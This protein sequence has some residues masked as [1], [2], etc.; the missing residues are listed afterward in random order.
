MYFL[1]SIVLAMAPLYIHKRLNYLT[2]QLIPPCL[3]PSMPHFLPPLPS[4]FPF[5][6]GLVCSTVAFDLLEILHQSFHRES[7]EEL[8]LGSVDTSCCRSGHR[9]FHTMVF[10]AAQDVLPCMHAWIPEKQANFNPRSTG[11]VR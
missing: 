9:Q 8:A 5:L 1:S 2:E 3:P 7:Y 10:E 6:A 4:S 11:P